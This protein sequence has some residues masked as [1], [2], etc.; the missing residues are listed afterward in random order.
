MLGT[1]ICPTSI[2]PMPTSTPVIHAAVSIFQETVEHD[3]SLSH[4]YKEERYWDQWNT[5]TIAQAHAQDIYKVFDLKYKAH[6]LAKKQLFM[7]K[8]KYI[9]VVF[10]NKLQTDYSKFFLTTHQ[11]ER[12]TTNLY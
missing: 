2:K 12:C 5:H 1:A 3:Q 11:R 9:F 10:T 6:T 7:M 8:Q 4:Q